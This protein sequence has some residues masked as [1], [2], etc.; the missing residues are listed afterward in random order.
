MRVGTGQVTLGAALLACAAT[1]VV[2]GQGGF[3]PAQYRDGDLP[4]ISIRALGGGQ[5]F[6]ELSV[7]SSGVVRSVTTLRATPPFTEAL[8]N[9]ARGWQFH[10]AEE[11]F[12]PAAGQP[13]DPKP[14]KPVESK[15]LVAGIFRPPSLNTPTLGEPPKDTASASEETPFPVTTTTPPYP[16]LARDAGVVLVEV[17]V[18]T[19]GRVADARV[20][21]SAPPFD[22]PAL[23]AA[24]QW[25]FRPARL[26]GASV[27]T[28]AYVVFGFRPPITVAPRRGSVGAEQR[29]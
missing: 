17:R 16:P 26:H 3:T 7:S 15:V 18:D 24:R 28:L 20:I 13:V 4:Q 29:R 1:I 8:S 12:E 6:L 9:V 25:T 22:E 14:R 23:D 21:R 27:A 2:L 10:P 19:G 5:V 11:E